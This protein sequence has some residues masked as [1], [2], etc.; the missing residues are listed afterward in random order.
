MCVD[1][2]VITYP[3]VRPNFYNIDHNGVVYNIK[4]GKEIRSYVD[5]KGYIRVQL[6]STK[7]NGRRIDVG[8][9]R[10]LCWEFNGP[11]TNENDVVNHIDGVKNNNNPRNLAWCSN[12]ENVKHAIDNGL[13]KISRRYDYDEETISTACD[14]IILGLTNMEITEYI[15]NGID[16]HSEEQGNFL[17]T[18]GCI[19]AGKSYQ[20]IYQNRLNNINYDDYKD[21]NKS[22]IKESIKSTKNVDKIDNLNEIIISYRNEGFSKIDILEKIT[23]YRSSSATV[24]TKR[25]YR[26]INGLFK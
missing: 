25:I 18:L 14:L 1:K 7:S 15:Y 10:L 17:T 4:N 8:V 6:Q 9:H 11:Y 21:I 20:K 5:G 19:R 23:G 3:G 16:I 22:N 2:Q 12:S 24:Y 26:I 13:L